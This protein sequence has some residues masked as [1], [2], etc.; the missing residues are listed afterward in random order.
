MA[1]RYFAK[2]PTIEYANTKCTNIT[3][4]PTIA[5][6]LDKNPSVFHK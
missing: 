5:Q 1:E 2:F 3:K 4:R 6:E